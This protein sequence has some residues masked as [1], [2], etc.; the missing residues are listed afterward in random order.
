VKDQAPSSSP[1]ALAHN[2]KGEF[3]NYTFQRFFH[4]TQAKRYG[5]HH[6]QVHQQQQQDRPAAQDLI[7]QPPQNNNNFTEF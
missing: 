2:D 1:A 6:Q 4:L 7:A 3:T 5:G